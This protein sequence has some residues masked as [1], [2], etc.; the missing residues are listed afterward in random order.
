MHSSVTSRAPW[1]L[2]GLITFVLM[3]AFVVSS[4]NFYL[5]TPILEQ[6]DSAVNALQIDNAKHGT[7]LYGNYSRFHFNHPGPVLFYVYAAGEIVLRDWLGIVPTPHNAHLLASLAVQIGCFALAL[8]LLH[9]WFDSWLFLALALFAG[10]WHFSLVPGAFNSLWPPHVLL[11]PFLCFMVAAGSFAAGRT[12]DLAIMIVLGGVL[13]HSHVAQPLFVGGLGALAAVL[14]WRREKQ[15]GTWPGGRAW[16]ASHRGLLWFC[17]AWSALMLLPLVIDVCLYGGES[18]VATIVRRFLRNTTEHKSVLQSLLYFLSFPTYAENQEDFLTELTPASYRFYVDHLPILLGWLAA[19][20]GTAWLAWF[21]R[22][23]LPP[24]LRDFLRT[25]YYCWGATALLCVVWGLLQSGQMFQFN[26]VFYHGV[27]F[28]LTLLGLGVLTHFFG[29]RCPGWVCAVLCSLAAIMA[30]QSFP[31]AATT[32]EQTGQSI[33]RGVMTILGKT[34]SRRPILLVFEHYIWPK[35]IPLALE[36][37]RLGIPFYTAS[38]WNFMLGRQHDSTLL[39]PAPEKVASIWWV[40]LSAPDGIAI[41]KDLSIFT[42]PAPIDPKGSEISFANKTNGFRYLVSGLSTGN[43]DYAWTDL[44]RTA[45]VFKPLPATKDVQ[46]IIEV[47]NNPRPEGNAAQTAEVLL[48]G[49]SLGSVTAAERQF[50]SL[51]VP[52][53]QWNAAAPLATLELKFPQATRIRN[54]S[55]PASVSWAAWGLW[56]ISFA[57]S[58]PAGGDI[59]APFAIDQAQPAPSRI[60]AAMPAIGGRINFTGTG[61]SARY[62]TSGLEK[63]GADAARTNAKR[64]EVLFRPAPATAPVQLQIVAQPYS[65]AGM[66]KMQRCELYFNDQIL[67]QSPFVGPG[68]LRVLIPLEIWNRR[69]VGMLRLQLPDATS[70]K[71]G[72]PASGLDIRWIATGPENSSP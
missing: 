18:N 47:Q 37:Q 68:V 61:N 63:P 67:F 23:D 7:E 72:T 56:S 62:F 41:T 57:T 10:L 19:F 8:A 39:G 4:W 28:F 31:M 22:A 49:V 34:P 25:A 52:Q 44:Q 13:F 50:F 27:Y 6:G 1:F 69:P 35:V 51:T 66:P 30:V 64:V 9:C 48:N 26:G 16:A 70:T 55:E 12:R 3:I 11:M 65:P 5:D 2:A 40:T 29:R 15:A 38:S 36:L 59:S 60:A 46:L 54:F 42:K 43:V 21:R 58:D 45:L 32:N 33:H 14:F 71:A 17:G 24:A 20:S 53:A